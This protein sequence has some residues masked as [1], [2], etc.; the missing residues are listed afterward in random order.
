[1]KVGASLK[2]IDNRWVR[3]AKGYRVQY[4]EKLNS[5][6]VTEYCPGIDDK[7]LDS[8][9]TTWRLAWKMATS[10]QTEG[11]TIAEGELVNVHVV[12][13]EGNPIRYYATG[14]F[15]RFNPKELSESG[16]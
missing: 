14:K 13:D 11:D 7:V 4:Q 1:M 6:L 2:L 8:D 12:D 15:D 5:D 10:T 16:D 9:I 3:K